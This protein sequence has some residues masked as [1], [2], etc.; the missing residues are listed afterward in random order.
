M[1]TFSTFC[2]TMLCCCCYMICWVTPCKGSALHA[3]PCAG[4]AGENVCFLSV[5]NN[6]GSCA[7]LLFYTIRIHS[8][9]SRTSEHF[10]L[11]LWSCS[12]HLFHKTALAS[13][14]HVPGHLKY[15][16][17]CMLL[18]AGNHSGA[19]QAVPCTMQS[20]HTARKRLIIGPTGS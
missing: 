20:H 12:V 11:V 17:T 14:E 3:Y 19:Q 10:S 2:I 8:C 15:V 4:K 13:D 6:Q 5:L 9:I 16:G 7:V 1:H 18:S